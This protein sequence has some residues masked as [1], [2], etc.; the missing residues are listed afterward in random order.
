[1]MMR[2]RRRK[3]R[4]RRAGKKLPS[5]SYIVGHHNESSEVSNVVT[6]MMTLNPI[7]DNLKFYTF[8]ISVIMCLK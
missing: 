5:Y 7:T 8:S 4:G 3:R 1:M 6:C 2:R